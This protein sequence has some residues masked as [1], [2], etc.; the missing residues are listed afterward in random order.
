MRFIGLTLLLV[1]LANPLH[2]EPEAK[3]SSE[4]TP[5]SVITLMNHYRSL[6]Q[7][8]PLQSEERIMKAAEDRM[9]DME[10]LGYWSH[11]PPD[12]RSPFFWLKYRSYRFTR[13]G[14]NLARGFETADL[15]VTSWMDSSGH[16]ENILGA[17]YHHVGVAVIDGATT[18]RYPGKSVVVL[19]G[20]E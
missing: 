9:R 1:I 2:A 11:E 7:L 12:G 8:P 14:E 4:I 20:R 17:E 13:A 18:G 3:I 6:N 15:L 19:F 16:R 10:E 5:Q